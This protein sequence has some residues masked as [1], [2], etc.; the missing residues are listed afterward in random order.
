MGIEYK[1]NFGLGFK[2][3]PPIDENDKETYRHTLDGL[4]E[5]MYDF[6]KYV[7]KSSHYVIL[8]VGDIYE[9]NAKI[10]YF[11][12]IKGC[13]LF[14]FGYDLTEAVKELEKYCKNT[15]IKTIGKFGLYGELFIG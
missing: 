6:A 5:D 2:I 3:S 12:F 8:T 14:E 7:K 10:E 15:N 13:H 4:L 1:A 11:I 9:P